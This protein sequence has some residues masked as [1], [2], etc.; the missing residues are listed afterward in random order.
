M[1]TNTK[2]AP[3]GARIGRLSG[4]NQQFAFLSEP[5]WETPP[6]AYW[7]RLIQ[8]LIRRP[9]LAHLA[10]HLASVDLLDLGG[11]AYGAQLRTHAM[12][13][14]EQ[15]EFCSNVSDF[16]QAFIANRLGVAVD[17][18]GV[19]VRPG[20][21]AM[22]RRSSPAAEF[23]AVHDAVAI[24][25]KPRTVVKLHQPPREPSV[26][27][28]YSATKVTRWVHIEDERS[29]IQDVFSWQASMSPLPDVDA[30]ADLRAALADA[31][32]ICIPSRVQLALI[33]PRE[34]HAI[35]QL[36]AH[37][38]TF[39][40]TL[41]IGVPDPTVA[42]VVLDL[43]RLRVRLGLLY[44]GHS[45]PPLSNMLTH[46]KIIQ[47]TPAKFAKGDT[48]QCHG[49]R[50]DLVFRVNA[51]LD[52]LYALEAPRPSGDIRW[53]C[54]YAVESDFNLDSDGI[55]EMQ[56]KPYE[57]AMM[58]CAFGRRVNVVHGVDWPF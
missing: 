55:F 11:G 40:R 4:T 16:S 6:T 57:Q 37:P 33:G 25:R 17:A 14:A 30:L 23:M 42:T 45:A 26:A 48:I 43:E 8:T 49:P 21:E 46:Q 36:A 3:L 15:Q 18:V 34:L 28:S 53:V 19:V 39:G 50:P 7:D 1:T 32:V 13:A 31:E 47:A 22:L 38:A 12:T 20:L 54:Q 24:S 56:A 27:A 51:V 2:N 29:A 9:R 41:L 52:G 5:L 44:A 10:K 58:D 35:E